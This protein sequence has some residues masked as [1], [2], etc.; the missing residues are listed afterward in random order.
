M[1]CL[2]SSLNF[3]DWRDQL[4]L[5]DKFSNNLQGE[6]ITA[7]AKRKR[8]A[9][10]SAW[11]QQPRSSWTRRPSCPRLLF[12]QLRCLRDYVRSSSFCV[13]M[14]NITW[15]WGLRLLYDFARHFSLPFD[16][17][18]ALPN[19]IDIFVFHLTSN[20]AH[21]GVSRIS[22]WTFIFV[23]KKNTKKSVDSTQIFPCSIVSFT[24]NFVGSLGRFILC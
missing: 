18:R 6:P 19:S 4:M 16:L 5:H 12:L 9:R 8:S 2:M 21:T 10:W 13:H 15:K 3:S 23:E 24:K 22:C 1:L 11:T 17:C 7:M 14:H 20:S